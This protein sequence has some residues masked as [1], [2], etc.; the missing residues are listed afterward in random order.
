VALLGRTEGGVDRASCD[1]DGVRLV[2]VDVDG[3]GEAPTIGVP[4]PLFEYDSAD[5]SYPQFSVTADAERFLLIKELTG[6]VS[7]RTELSLVRNWFE[8]LRR[9]TSTTR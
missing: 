1:I 2:A 7:D 9:I 6:A 3:E 4:V 8:E 5:N